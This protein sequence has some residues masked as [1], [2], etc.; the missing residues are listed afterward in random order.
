VCTIQ[1]QHND[2]LLTIQEQQSDRLIYNSPSALSAVWE[3]PDDFLNLDVEY[4]ADW[5]DQ[6]WS[7]LYFLP[8]LNSQHNADGSSLGSGSSSFHPHESTSD[9]SSVPGPTYVYPNSFLDAEASERTS[10]VQLSPSIAHEPTHSRTEAK[11][12]PVEQIV[13]TFS[14]PETSNH[15]N[16]DNNERPSCLLLPAPRPFKCEL[17]P[18]RFAERRQLQ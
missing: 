9:I 16:S 5:N 13:N 17:C 14:S 10:T 11:V 4:S 3:Q 1:E 18:A 12:L 8:G 7:D 2:R 6:V 15:L